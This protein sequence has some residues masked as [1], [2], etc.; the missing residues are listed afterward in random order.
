M[1]RLIRTRSAPAAQDTPAV[2]GAPGA[3][4]WPA[5][6]HADDLIPDG[7]VAVRAHGVQ[8]AIF[9]TDEGLFALDNLDPFSGAAVLARGIVGELRG[10]LV[11]ASPMYK[12]HFRLDTGQCLED[13]S[14]SVRCWPLCEDEAGMIYVGPPQAPERRKGCDHAAA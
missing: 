6:C 2:P 4:A 3:A 14:V 7:G 10:C 11:V 1:S 12:Q 5:V 8:I 9:L 13:A